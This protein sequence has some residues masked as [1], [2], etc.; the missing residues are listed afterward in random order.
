MGSNVLVRI[1]PII[2]MGENYRLPPYILDCLVELGFI[3]FDHIWRPSWLNVS[4]SC[5]LTVVDLRLGSCW[6][7]E[8]DNYISRLNSTDIRLNT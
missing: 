2:G 6:V 4:Y 1:D 5:W 3:T 8:W 7:V